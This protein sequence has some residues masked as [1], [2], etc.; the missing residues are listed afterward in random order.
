MH[1]RV[2]DI[3]QGGV[4]EGLAASLVVGQVP[5]LTPTAVGDIDRGSRD[6]SLDLIDVAYI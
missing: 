1:R 3:F 5:V 4:A 6:G 2:A